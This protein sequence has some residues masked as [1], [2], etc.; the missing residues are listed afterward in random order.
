MA[1]SFEECFEMNFDGRC[2]EFDSCEECEEECDKCPCVDCDEHPEYKRKQ[3]AIR[4]QNQIRH[5]EF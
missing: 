2:E 4:L 1:I 3:R 5:H